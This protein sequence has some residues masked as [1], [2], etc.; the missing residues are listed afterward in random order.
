MDADIILIEYVHQWFLTDVKVF[1]HAIN[2]PNFDKKTP[3]KGPTI[4][5][6]IV[7]FEPHVFVVARS[8]HYCGHPTD[9]QISKHRYNIKTVKNCETRVIASASILL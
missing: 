5:L 6:K 4:G 7:L 3:K 9:N 2:S 1:F 8:L